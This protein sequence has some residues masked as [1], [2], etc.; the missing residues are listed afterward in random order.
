MAISDHLSKKGNDVVHLSRNANPKSKYPTYEWN[1]SAGTIDPT[2]LDSDYVM[3][4]AGA[5][6]GDQ[7]WTE[8][9]KRQILESRVKGTKLLADKFGEVDNQ[10]KGI[11]QASAIGI[12]PYD[13]INNY[14]EDDE[15]G[16]HFLAEVVKAW[17]EAADQF[18]SLEIPVCKLR[19]GV[20][21]TE[22]G[23]ALPKMATPIKLGVGSPI[24]TG[25][26][27]MSWVHIDDLVNCFDFA[28]EKRLTGPYNLVAPNP[29]SNTEITAALA[30]ALHRWIV[31]PNVPSFVMKLIFGQMSEILLEGTSASSS[32]IESEGFV[33]KFDTIEKALRNIYE[34][35]KY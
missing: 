11:I 27:I 18:D 29:V 2:V 23:G 20:V 35:N 13:E 10:L 26:Q 25:K 16:D 22:Q 24:G 8:P 30:K 7:R 31:F 15:Q 28:L 9:R 6:V 5:G 14:H 32:K 17:E 1:P 4:L 34:S 33:F 21:L 12:Y 3:N 19:I